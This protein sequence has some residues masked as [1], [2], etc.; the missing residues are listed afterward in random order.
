MS[1]NNDITAKFDVYYRNDDA[2]VDPE[3]AENS[4]AWTTTFLSDA[5][6]VK[7]VLKNGQVIGE[8]ETIDVLMEAKAPDLDPK[9]YATSTLN[10]FNAKY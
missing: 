5:T 4:S 2:P 3:Q 7:L 10:T 1:G 8:Y 9:L 6:A